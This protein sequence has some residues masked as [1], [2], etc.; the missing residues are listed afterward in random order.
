MTTD[1]TAL[2]VESWIDVTAFL[3]AALGTLAFSL[4]GRLAAHRREDPTDPEDHTPAIR[5]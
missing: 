4:R 5:R 3:V 2:S 1:L